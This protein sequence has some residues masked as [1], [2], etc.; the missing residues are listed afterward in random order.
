[1][2]QSINISLNQDWQCFDPDSLVGEDDAPY[3]AISDITQW[4]SDDG[5]DAGRLM[6]KRTFQL[7]AVDYCVQ[8]RL[9]IAA[10][11]PKTDVY[12]GD[13]MDYLG[14]IQSDT[15]F[16]Q[17]VTQYVHLGENTLTLIVTEPGT[18]GSIGLHATPCD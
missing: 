10:A 7:D 8:Y 16:S 6:F 11:P 17:D 3:Q 12:I 15:S 4:Y 14:Q 5:I 9:N 2:T 13:A 1:M 18:F